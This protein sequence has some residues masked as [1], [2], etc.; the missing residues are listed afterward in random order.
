MLRVSKTVRVVLL[1]ARS[2]RINVPVGLRR[3]YGNAAVVVRPDDF[4]GVAHFVS[5]LPEA[6]GDFEAVRAVAV[7]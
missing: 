4:L 5:Y 7:A 3:R 1:R 6:A 2:V